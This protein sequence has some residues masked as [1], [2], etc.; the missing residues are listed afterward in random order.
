MPL[1]KTERKK[2]AN[3]Y[4]KIGIMR[5]DYILHNSPI[6]N[7]QSEAQGQHLRFFDIVAKR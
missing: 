1:K 6:S 7:Q 4:T 2:D 3:I 5:C